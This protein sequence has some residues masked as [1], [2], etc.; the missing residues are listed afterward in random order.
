MTLN[1]SAVSQLDFKPIE[2]FQ[3]TYIII[4]MTKKVY[5]LVLLKISRN[6][7]SEGTK[8]SQLFDFVLFHSLS[9]FF[10][11]KDYNIIAFFIYFKFLIFLNYFYI[12]ICL[13]IVLLFHQTLGSLR[14]GTVFCFPYILSPW[15]IECV[16]H[17]WLSNK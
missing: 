6:M 12:I 4:S 8:A 3:L 13:I 14:I 15:H 10:V 9:F 5:F 2:F 7:K 16:F 11:F 17:T 1:I